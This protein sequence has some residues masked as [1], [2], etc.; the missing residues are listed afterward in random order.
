MPA[1][2]LAMVQ[3]LI[4]RILISLGIGFVTFEAFNTFVQ[5]II[6]NITTQM[7]GL[8]PDVLQIITLYGLPE[9]LGIV[10]G[11][12]VTAASIVAIKGMRFT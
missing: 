12:F 4:A 1:F 5:S 10:L 3:P 9:A 2:L 8:A 6:T 7:N 11:G